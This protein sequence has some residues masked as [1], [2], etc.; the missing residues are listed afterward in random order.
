M[1]FRAVLFDLDGT[2][3]NTLD[4]L[5]D[6]MNTAL[7]KNGFPTHPVASYKYFVGDG[8][9]NLVLRSLPAT[10]H[11]E[12]TVNSL[13]AAQQEEY[14]RCWAKKTRP[15]VGVPELL[16]ELQR[17]KIKLCVLSNKP[18]QFAKIT[19]EKFLPTT[20]FAIVRGESND[21]PRKPDPSGAIRIAS[22]LK[23]SPTKFLYV[24]DTGT[25]MK[26]GV[27]ASMFPVGVL[28]GFRPPEELIATGA[29]A[30]IEQ[31]IDLLRLWT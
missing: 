21:T 25:D 17:L 30:L 7:E 13:M 27:A 20:K 29:K 18:D 12:T 24:G 19:I 28:W 10:N 3:L 2:L 5:A 9:V 11:D 1:R 31:P 6:S 15:Y 22:E 4:D 23:L 26:T 14:L 8:L 16:D